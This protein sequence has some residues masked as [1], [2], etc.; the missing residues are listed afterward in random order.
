MRVDRRC[1][2]PAVRH[3]ACAH[4]GDVRLGPLPESGRREGKRDHHLG[5]HVHI[6]RDVARGEG[7]RE[8]CDGEG[9][10]DPHGGHFVGADDTESHVVRGLGRRELALG[11]S[12]HE[13]LVH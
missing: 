13:H 9:A 7:R 10:Y 3:Q 5:R 11:D 12:R 8:P 4:L 1:G 6:G 2:T